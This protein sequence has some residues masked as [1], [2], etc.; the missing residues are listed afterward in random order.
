MRSCIT[1]L[2]DINEWFGGREEKW[3]L[4]T[5]RGYDRFGSSGVMGRCVPYF[6]YG[7]GED[8]MVAMIGIGGCTGS[9]RRLEVCCG[10][11]A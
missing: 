5:G 2:V 1:K 8:A 4:V 6:V 9:V 3:G 11:E 10:W 7:Y